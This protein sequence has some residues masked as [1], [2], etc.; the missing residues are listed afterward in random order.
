MFDGIVLCTILPNAISLLTTLLLVLSLIIQQKPSV[1]VAI[2]ISY[3]ISFIL[4][5]ISLIICFL[6]NK[7]STKELVLEK[8]RLII[9]GNSYNLNEIAS[10]EYYVCKWYAIPI[11][12]FYKEQLGGLMEINLRSGKTIKIKI[13]YRE[14]MKIKKVINDIKEK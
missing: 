14:Y 11:A 7:N 4:L 3:S 8:S 2:A 1:Y 13:L 12:F 6:I 9:F 10:C 5:T